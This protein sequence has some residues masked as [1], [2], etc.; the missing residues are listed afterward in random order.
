MSFH[1]VELPPGFQYGS[2]AGAGFATIVQETASGHE[3]RIA[4]QSQGRHRLR[5]IK[6]LQT[7]A[8]AQALKRFALARRGALHSFKVRDES[9]FTTNPDGFSTPDGGDCAIGVGDGT[10]T[11]PFQLQKKY[12]DPFS[13][14]FR[15]ITLPVTGSVVVRLDGVLTSAF[16]VN[17]QG[18]VMLDTPAGSGVIIT[19]GCEFYVPVRFGLDFDQW[20]AL[21]ADAFNTW[22]L[23]SLDVIEVLD[24]VQNP[25]RLDPNGGRDYGSVSAGFRLSFN[26]GCLHHLSPTGP[27]N[28]FLP[29]PTGIPGGAGIFRISVAAG[30]AG[31]V[32]VRDD[33][34]NA[35]GSALTA[36]QVRDLDLAIDASNGATWIIG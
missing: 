26:D 10:S 34:G 35:I 29:P 9:D 24:E 22:S 13:P 33:A 7:T 1:D 36:G 16:T 28:L 19:A 4:R 6:G 14:Y 8:E 20:A 17:G 32:Q 15:T 25:E 30:A 5:L 27:I 12:D 23:P 2:A 18:Q 3:V 31:S 21:Q 11:G